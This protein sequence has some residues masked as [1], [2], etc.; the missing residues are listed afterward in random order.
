MT[1]ARLFT[2]GHLLRVSHQS[3]V[4]GEEDDGGMRPGALGRYYS[5]YMKTEKNQTPQLEDANINEIIP[6]QW[7]H[8]SRVSNEEGVGGV[9]SG[10]Y[11]I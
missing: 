6:S 5:V 3:C 7:S 2:N 11:S 10:A 9:R 4:S 1:P 8:Q